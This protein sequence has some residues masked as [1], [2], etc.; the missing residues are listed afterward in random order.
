MATPL[1]ELEALE[2][3]LASGARRVKYADRE[4][5]YRSLA[6]MRALIEEKKRELGLSRRGLQ[7]DYLKTDKDLG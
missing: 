5:E 6:D 3:A 4:I 2:A 7:F 1:S